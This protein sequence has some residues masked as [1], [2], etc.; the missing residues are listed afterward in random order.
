[1]PN[2]VRH[3][4]ARVD[5]WWVLKVFINGQHVGGVEQKGKPRANEVEFHVRQAVTQ[6]EQRRSPAA[7][8]S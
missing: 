3:T 6:Y 1:M 5:G 4:L 7:V 8:E 2:E